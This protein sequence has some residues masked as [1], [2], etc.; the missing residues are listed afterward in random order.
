MY[1]T[2]AVFK[3]Q[4]IINDREYKMDFFSKY[5]LSKDV[6]QFQ[7]IQLRM[8]LDTWDGEF[9]MW[10]TMNWNLVSIKWTIPILNFENK[11]MWVVFDLAKIEV[12]YSLIYETLYTDKIDITY[13]MINKRITYKL[14][15]FGK[16]IAIVANV[17]WMVISLLVNGT[18]YLTSQIKYK[19]LAEYLQKL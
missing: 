4:E 10:Y 16:D 3:P 18:Q 17:D 14:D 12:L 5:T 8:Y 7:D 11:L 19:S 15:Y 1:I 6:H 13:N 9:D 2:W